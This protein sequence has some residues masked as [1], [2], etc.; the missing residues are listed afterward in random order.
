MALKIGLFSFAFSAPGCIG[1]SRLNK[2]NQLKQLKRLKQ[3]KQLNQRMIFCGS[4][5]LSGDN[6]L[7][8]RRYRPL[9]NGM[10]RISPPKNPAGVAQTA[11]HH[12]ACPQQH[13]ADN[14][15]HPNSPPVA[16]IRH[17]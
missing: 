13:A 16:A 5:H 10:S 2:L 6:N 1:N 4:S 12:A 17:K 3:P 14:R 11:R 8:G 9:V 15:T 7:R